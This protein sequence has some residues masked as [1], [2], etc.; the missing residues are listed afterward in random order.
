MG[1]ALGALLALLVSVAGYWISTR[2]ERQR[3]KLL[4]EIRQLERSMAAALARGDRV[5]VAELAD[6]LRWLRIA[7]SIGDPPRAERPSDSPAGPDVRR[8]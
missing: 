4:E 5:H 8:P 1:T 6:R 3:R 7:A 2:K